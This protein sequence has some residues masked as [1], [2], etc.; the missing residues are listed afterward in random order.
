MDRLTQFRE[1]LERLDGKQPLRSQRDADLYVDRPDPV[2]QTLARHLPVR[3]GS[4]H[5]VTG[6]IGCGKST[7]LLAAGRVLTSTAGIFARY[8]DLTRLV[9]V[10]PGQFDVQFAALMA[11]VYAGLQFEAPN[12]GRFQIAKDAWVAYC[13]ELASRDLFEH[14]PRSRYKLRPFTDHF[15]PPIDPV[16]DTP[17]HLREYVEELAYL[18]SLM[19]QFKFGSL[20]WLIDG[21][22][23]QSL[24]DNFEEFVEPLL[25]A[26]AAAEVGLAI[27]A[28]FRASMGVER[29]GIFAEFKRV[30]PVTPPD[31]STPAG[32]EFLA[33]VLARRTEAQ[34]LGPV[35][36]SRIAVLSGGILRHL[37]QLAEAA[38]TNAWVRGAAAVDGSDVDFA[39]S[40]LGR[41]LV[42]GLTDKEIQQLRQ[43]AATGE[44]V[45]RDWEDRALIQTNRVLQYQGPSG[46]P[47]HRVH[48]CIVPFLTAIGGGHP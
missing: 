10:R 6:P 48:P 36:R 40:D 45:A 1:V 32:E 46:P 28:P 31:P 7:E 42:F 26:C 12:E 8:A 41:D 2:A 9:D 24:A 37:L 19:H 22:D 29:A 16:R 5:L 47:I 35:E 27:V 13:A 43:V 21:L 11:D 14:I 25:Q 34:L 4:C 17:A 38:L 23:R 44:F 39:A 3:P 18:K 20:V 33:S 30:I 15:A